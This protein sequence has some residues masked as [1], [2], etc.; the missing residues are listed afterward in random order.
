MALALID[1]V[2]LIIGII[3]LVKWN[4]FEATAKEKLTMEL[5]KNYNEDPDLNDFVNFVQEEVIF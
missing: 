5:I 4:D 2:L 3:G 1:I